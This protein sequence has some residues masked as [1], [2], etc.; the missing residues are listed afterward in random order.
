MKRWK[1]RLISWWLLMGA[2][3]IALMILGAVREAQTWWKYEVILW[4]LMAASFATL[5]ILGALRKTWAGARPFAFYFLAAIF[6]AISLI[7]P[8]RLGTRMFAD[9]VF[10]VF[11]AIAIYLTLKHL[12]IAPNDSAA[13]AS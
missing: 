2:G 6:K 12:R 10:T 5:A 9:T 7:R 4:L 1:Y 3:I 11:L 13:R 8:I